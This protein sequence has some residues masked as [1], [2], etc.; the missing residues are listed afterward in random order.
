MVHARAASLAAGRPRARN[1]CSSP[2]PSSPPPCPSHLQLHRR[3][4]HGTLTCIISTYRCRRR[5]LQL[6]RHGRHGTLT[7]ISTATM[8]MAAAP[9]QWW[10]RVHNLVK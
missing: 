8:R 4:R 2:L 3:G 9:Q 10:Q 5:N 7:C 6:H 1:K